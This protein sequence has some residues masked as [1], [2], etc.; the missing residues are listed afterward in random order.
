VYHVLNRA[1]AK[2]RIFEHDRDYLAF[3][4]VLGEVQERVPMRILAWCVMPNHLIGLCT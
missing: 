2:R 4:R 3:E 1:N